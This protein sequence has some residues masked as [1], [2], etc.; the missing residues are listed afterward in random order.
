M[1]FTTVKRENLYLQFDFLSTF[2]IIQ[3]FFHQ[4]IQH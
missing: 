4:V 2:R 1:R 3:H